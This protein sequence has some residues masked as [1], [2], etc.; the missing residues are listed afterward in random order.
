M[1]TVPLCLLYQSHVRHQV[2]ASFNCSSQ[3]TLCKANWYFSN[4]SAKLIVVEAG[5]YFCVSACRAARL[6]GG[7]AFLGSHAAMIAAA[8]SANQD[9]K[10]LW[11]LS[12]GLLG[13]VW[14][15]TLLVM[16][17]TNKKILQQVG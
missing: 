8:K 16:L 12:S 4:T 7:L 2:A 13:A 3:V 6:Q 10:L 5:L 1:L 9:S 11:S 15:F 14:P 17:P